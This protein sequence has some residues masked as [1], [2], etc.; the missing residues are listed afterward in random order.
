MSAN[1]LFFVWF[2]LVSDI[3]YTIKFFLKKKRLHIYLHLHEL[4][5]S[6]GKTKYL[7]CTVWTK[8]HTT[9]VYRSVKRNM[10]TMKEGRNSIDSYISPPSAALRAFRIVWWMSCVCACV[11]MKIYQTDSS[12]VHTTHATMEHL[13]TIFGD[14][15]IS[16]PL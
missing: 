12:T 15:I 3:S 10:K 4:V 1:L 11:E 9:E 16:R 8:S 13:K 7:Q 14:H 6:E 5:S 2:L